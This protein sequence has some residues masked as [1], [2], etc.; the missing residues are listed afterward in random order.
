MPDK[1]KRRLLDH[2]GQGVRITTDRQVYF[3]ERDGQTLKTFTRYSDAY[4][5]VG[6][7]L[8]LEE[9]VNREE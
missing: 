4:D 9:P 1:R 3:V 5:Y 2:W 8:G 7:A 6:T